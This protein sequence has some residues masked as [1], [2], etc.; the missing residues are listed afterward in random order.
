MYVGSC[1]SGR[2]ACSRCVGELAASVTV[3]GVVEMVKC[4]SFKMELCN[5]QNSVMLNTSEGARTNIY[6]SYT[7]QLRCR[8]PS[9]LSAECSN[10][11]PVTVRWTQLV[12]GWVTIGR[13]VNLLSM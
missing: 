13:W 7:V 1:K 10:L 2:Q 9:K 4:S 11:Q 5:T 3:P 12:F 8:L 6:N